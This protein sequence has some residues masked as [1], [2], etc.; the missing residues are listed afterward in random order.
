MYLYADGEEFERTYFAWGRRSIDWRN[1]IQTGT[2]ITVRTSELLYSGITKNADVTFFFA[3]KHSV[4]AS[5]VRP[6]LPAPDN[7]RFQRFNNDINLHWDIDTMGL[8]SQGSEHG[9]LMP[10]LSIQL[11]AND[12]HIRT[13]GPF[14]FGAVGRQTRIDNLNLEPGDVIQLRAIRGNFLYDNSELSDIIIVGTQSVLANPTGFRIDDNYIISWDAVYG[15]THYEIFFDNRSMGFP[16]VNSFRITV[17]E[18][19]IYLNKIMYRFMD[20]FYIYH[21]VVRAISTDAF[22]APSQA[23]PILISSFMD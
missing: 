17:Y 7:L 16:F 4:P 19:S 6:R 20:E 5:F 22:A 21:I 15:A 18:A 8:R 3:S 9:T 12:V 1:F 2:Q 23:W 11:F 10:I 14:G 13:V